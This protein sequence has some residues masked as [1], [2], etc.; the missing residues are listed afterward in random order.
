MYLMVWVWIRK[1]ENWESTK[2]RSTLFLRRLIEPIC[3]WIKQIIFPSLSF[4][5]LDGQKKKSEKRVQ[6]HDYLVF[7]SIT[8]MYG[9]GL[10]MN[11]SLQNSRFSFKNDWSKFPRDLKVNRRSYGCRRIFLKSSISRTNARFMSLSY[12]VIVTG[13]YNWVI[14]LKADSP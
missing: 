13:F 6:W 8:K 14:I 7:T 2:C 4:C 3:H 5:P 10:L 1:L 12:P 11:F 9:R